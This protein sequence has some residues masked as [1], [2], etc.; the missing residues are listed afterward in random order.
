MRIQRMFLTA[1]ARS[2]L[3]EYGKESEAG[4]EV[5]Q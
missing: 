3:V 2:R 1:L 4:R 5:W